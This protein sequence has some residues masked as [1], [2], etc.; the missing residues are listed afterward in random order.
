MVFENKII[1]KKIELHKPHPGNILK[2]YQINEILKTLKEWG[3]L[4]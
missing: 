1:N 3:I 4:Q 2:T